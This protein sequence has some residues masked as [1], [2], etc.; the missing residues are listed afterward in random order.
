MKNKTH[1]IITNNLHSIAEA[2]EEC[3]HT[4]LKRIQFIQMEL[5]YDQ[6]D[7]EEKTKSRPES[8]DTN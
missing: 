4:I 2:L 5:K 8:S 7:N 6:E 3:S 1:Q